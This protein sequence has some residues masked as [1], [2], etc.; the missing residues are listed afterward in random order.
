MT[1]NR[2][3]LASFILKFEQIQNY[4]FLF[5]KYKIIIY[6]LLYTDIHNKNNTL[7]HHLEDQPKLRPVNKPTAFENITVYF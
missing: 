7:W 2:F 3:T 1:F 4:L 5:F 6:Y